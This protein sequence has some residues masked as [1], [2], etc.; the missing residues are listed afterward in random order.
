[1][2][3]DLTADA[4]SN[5]PLP[6]PFVHSP[7][8]IAKWVDIVVSCLAH[9]GLKQSERVTEMVVKHLRKRGVPD[10]TIAEALSQSQYQFIYPMNI[11]AQLVVFMP[12]DPSLFANMVSQSQMYARGPQSLE[13]VMAEVRLLDRV[14]MV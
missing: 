10:K 6:A 8:A 13:D 7:F 12:L 3:S 11:A 1:M 9:P 5:I 14:Y 4:I 2:P